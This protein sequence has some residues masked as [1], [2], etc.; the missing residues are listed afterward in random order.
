MLDAV[1]VGAGPN[2]LAAAITLAQAG[3][4]V[5]VYEARATVGGGMRSAE[6]TRPG[7]VHDICSAIHPL[8]MGSPF[9]SQLPLADYGLTWI[10]PDLPLA[11]PLDDGTAVALHRSVSETA[12]S[13][14][15]DGTA[16]RRLLAALA[17]HWPQLAG[18]ILGP[19][20][21]FP[22][23]PLWMARFG[24]AAL[25]S[26][27]GL[28][29]LIF[30]TPQ[31]RA[32][33]AGNAAHSMLP[34]EA[35]LSASFGLVLLLLGHAVGWPLPRGGSQ[36][37]ADALAAHLQTLGGEI[38]TDHP[39]E[40][41]DALPPARAVLLDV[42]PRQLLQIAGER[43][44]AGYRRALEK[45][46]YG[47]GV[48]KVDYALAGPIPWQAPECRRA[49]TV[50]VGGSLAEIAASESA[51]AQGRTPER[52]FVLVTQ[53]SLFDDSRA[54]QG[55]HTAW[56]YCHVPHGSTE[57]QTARIEQQ[58]ERFAPGFRDL[59]LARHVMNSADLHRY[60]AN[61]IGGD[62]N[63]GVQDFSQLFFRPVPRRVPYATPVRGLYLCSASTPPGG[64]VHG[65]CGYHAARAVL[66][67]QGR[68][69]LPH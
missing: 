53:P 57:D 35:P 28:A 7:F 49:G 25:P 29:Q 67:A 19:L 23:H 21:R 26:A 3:W 66:R 34:L 13:L 69:T 41:L 20:L 60:N 55:Q 42:S 16:Y 15:R 52:P 54:P 11:H 58:I 39:V 46:R 6:L 33:L 63:G 17:E 44:P 2:G 31:A 65:M 61:Y 12:A 22:R 24:L 27:S 8:G 59:I 64:G 36:K 5:R 38:V 50:H 51:A 32:L 4:S 45:Y 1:V 43:L 68:E 18:D 14:G 30:R 47:M 62:I 48:F 56:A 9:F 10:Q 40:Q 37:I